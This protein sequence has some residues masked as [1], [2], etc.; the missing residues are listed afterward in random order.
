MKKGMTMVGFG[1]DGGVEIRKKSP[2]GQL[3]TLFSAG[4]GDKL[5][6]L[7]TKIC[8]DEEMARGLGRQLLDLPSGAREEIFSLLTFSGSKFGL[9]SIGELTSF[10]LKASS[11]VR[12]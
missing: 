1:K 10:E 5:L 3:L 7:K 2:L 6:V 12:P 4:L 9:F 11:L 8:C